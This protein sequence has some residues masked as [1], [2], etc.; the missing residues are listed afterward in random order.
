MLS[1]TGLGDYTVLAQALCQQSL[2][3]GVVDLVGACVGQVLP[4]KVDLCAA[5]MLSEVG[6]VVKGCGSSSIGRVKGI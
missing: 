3:Q 4:L 6:R 5:T 2:S 1:R